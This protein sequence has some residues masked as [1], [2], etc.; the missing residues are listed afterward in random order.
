MRRTRKLLATL[1]IIGV[2]GALAG[3]GTFSAFSATTDNTGNQFA[4]GTVAISDND[5]GAAMYNVSNQAP[6][7]TVESCIKVTYTGSLPADVSLYTD[8][9]VGALGG[10]LDLDVYVGTIPPADPFGDCT[11]FVQDS[12][13]FNNTLSN[14]ATNNVDFASGLVAYPGGG[15][16]W[17]QND[18]LAYRFVLTMQDNPLAEGQ[19]TGAHRFVWEAQ[20]Q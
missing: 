16:Q 13:V 5:A 8:S 20:N 6:L 2:V 11:N 7:A 4:S 15:T 17:S 10:Y 9:A 12:Q 18:V 19:T 14:F 3:V 1:L